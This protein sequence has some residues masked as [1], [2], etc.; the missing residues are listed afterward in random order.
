MDEMPWISV[1]VSYTQPFEGS[2]ARVKQVGLLERNQPLISAACKLSSRAEL[3]SLVLNGGN[4]FDSHL[5]A[6]SP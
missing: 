2:R 3:L 5:T 4:E 1:W 6:V